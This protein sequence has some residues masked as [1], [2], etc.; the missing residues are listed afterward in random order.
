MFSILAGLI[1]LLAIVLP[2]WLLCHF[3]PRSWYL[4]GLSIAAALIIGL[5]PGTALL[6]SVAGTFIYGF[7]FFVLMVWGI[8][9][10]CVSIYRLA[11]HKPGYKQA[12]I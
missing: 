1:Y 10:L 2:V 11:T 7:V 6:E 8:G 9:G 12:A 4:H 3:G 5:M